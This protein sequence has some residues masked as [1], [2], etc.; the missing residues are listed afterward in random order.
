M[1]EIDMK[2]DYLI[3]CGVFGNRIKE[4]YMG[5]WIGIRWYWRGRKEFVWYIKWIGIKGRL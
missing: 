2:I 3:L 5:V 1:E 4:G